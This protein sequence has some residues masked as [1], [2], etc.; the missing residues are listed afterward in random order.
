MKLGDV[1]Q[2]IISVGG[3]ITFLDKT[4]KD[5]MANGLTGGSI[6]SNQKM[7]CKN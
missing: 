2:K 1:T 5:Q 4:L 7:H 6:L 3:M